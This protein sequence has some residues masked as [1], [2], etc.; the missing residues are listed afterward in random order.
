MT[1]I[2]HEDARR[3]MQARADGLLSETERLALQTHLQNC[4]SCQAK[5]IELQAL[6]EQLAR[7]LKTHLESKREP[8]VNLLARVQEITGGTS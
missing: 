3:L 4:E 8:S 7:V 5:A 1:L 6:D 2:S